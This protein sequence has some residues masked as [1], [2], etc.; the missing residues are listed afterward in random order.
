VIALLL[1]FGVFAGSTSVIFIKLSTEHPLLLAAYRQLIAAAALSPLFIRAWRRDRPQ[2]V[3]LSRIFLRSSLPGFILALHFITWIGGSRLTLAANATLIVNLV[4]VVMPFLL[5]F[6]VGERVGR[7]EIVGTALA[8]LGVGL[9]AGSDMH[10]GLD[11]WRG[12]TLCLASML[13]YALYLLLA[14][15][16]RGGGSIW[17]Y[18]VPL[19]SFGGFLCLAAGFVWAEPVKS[20]P[21]SEILLFLALGIVPTVIGHTVINYSMRRM[22]GQIVSVVVMAEFV[23]ASIMAFFLL[24]ESPAL[25]FYPAAAL[26][27]AGALIVLLQAGA[28]SAQ[29]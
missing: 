29:E 3:D 20:Y 14:K 10:L 4:P 27:V 11:T 12:D 1:I 6:V 15:R 24:G 22:R 17:L 2:G 9:L 23:F 7:R 25:A 8:L 21:T 18:V 16:S 28:T 13:C 5:F 26:V 19:Y